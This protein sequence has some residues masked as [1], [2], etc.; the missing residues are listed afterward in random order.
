MDAEVMPSPSDEYSLQIELL[1]N[2][3]FS[4]RSSLAVDGQQDLATRLSVRLLLPHIKPRGDL[5]IAATLADTLDHHTPQSD[6][7]ART[8]LALCRS[9][10][11][12]KNVRVLD[13][14][15][16][17]ALSRY[18]HYVRDQRPGGSVYWL[19]AGM[20]LE[21]L[22]LCADGTERTGSWQRYLSSGVCYRLLFAICMETTQSLLKGLLGDEDGAAL[23]YARARE[24]VTALEESTLASYVPCAQGLSHVVQMASAIVERKD[25]VL[26]ASS[27]VACLEEKRNEEDDGVVMSLAR[28]SMHWDLLRLAQL[29][30]EK[31]VER[32]FSSPFDVRGM[33]VLLERFTVVTASRELERL[34]P[35]STEETM[36]MRTALANGLMRAFVAENSKK[37]RAVTNP[38]GNF[39][40]A[41]IFAADLAKHSRDKQEKV[42]EMMLD[43]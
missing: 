40:V 28:S 18:W 36:K 3:S 1:L 11:K 25:D 22:V 31:N 23:V 26:V 41:G 27:I 20:E 13:G 32:D 19:L 24:M 8:L 34:K 33:Q 43:I 7:E 17:I 2:A 15:V 16:S 38:S 6:A 37:K 35:L 39:S 30:L 21:S 10:V 29:L 9:L 4:I 12:R 42:V 14:C 5:R